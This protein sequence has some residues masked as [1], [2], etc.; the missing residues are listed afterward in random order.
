MQLSVEARAI[1]SKIEGDVA[2]CAP[3]FSAM[4]TARN[5]TFWVGNDTKINIAATNSQLRAV[6]RP[7]TAE[8]YESSQQTSI[9][10]LQKRSNAL[11]KT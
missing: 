2:A 11:Y 1:P 3:L 9:L 10:S 6:W 7:S 4:D 5:W 8:K